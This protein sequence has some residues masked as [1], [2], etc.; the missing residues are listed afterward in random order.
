ML[1]E[2]AAP[3]GGEAPACPSYRRRMSPVRVKGQ[4]VDLCLGCG[5]LWV[6]EGELVAMERAAAGVKLEKELET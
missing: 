5:S 4:P 1:R 3:F 6:D 2:L